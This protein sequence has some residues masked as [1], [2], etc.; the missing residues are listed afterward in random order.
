MTR[1]ALVVSLGALCACDITTQQVRRTFPVEVRVSLPT[2][3]LETGWTVSDVS[4]SI[5]LTGL[6]VYEGR[7]LV[8]DWSP[9]SLLISTAHAHPGH[10]VPGESVAEVLAPVTLD[11]STREN[12]RWD[13]ANAV[14]AS[15][16][17][18]QLEL[19]AAGVRLTGTASRNDQT[20][21]FDTGVF[22]PD[23]A[24]TAIPFEHEMTTEPGRL[25]LTVDLAVLLSRIEF[26]KGLAVPDAEGLTRFDR[27]SQAFNGFERGVTD[28][29][30]YRFT[31]QPD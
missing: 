31:W 10:Y 7:V 20:L 23:A 2:T 15:Y 19:G 28:T 22:T 24:I 29:S 27:A 12:V 3:P 11:L 13:V 18:A 17:S 30:S 25:L 26:D 5:P 4:G 1:L 16:G 9:L 14:T 8:A 6:R 21:R